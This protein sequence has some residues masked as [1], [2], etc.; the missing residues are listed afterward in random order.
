M[1]NRA[2]IRSA[3]DDWLKSILSTVGRR[4]KI[5]YSGTTDRP[6]RELRKLKEQ[7]Y[8]ICRTAQGKSLRYEQRRL[9]SIGAVPL[10]MV[11]K[12]GTFCSSFMATGFANM[13][14]FPSHPR[15]CTKA[16]RMWGAGAAAMATE[17]RRRARFLRQHSDPLFTAPQRPGQHDYP[18]S[19]EHVKLISVSNFILWWTQMSQR[20][21]NFPWLAGR[22]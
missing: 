14:W 17:S 11:E 8:P 16:A 4:W 2:Q 22:S 9:S 13:R 1:S 12:P 21:F 20:I 10:L 7:K 5:W 6:V 3:H 19:G 18:R 15:R